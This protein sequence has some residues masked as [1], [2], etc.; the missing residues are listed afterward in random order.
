MK[1]LTT[2]TNAAK[3][4][5]KCDTVEFKIGL[6]DDDFGHYIGDLIDDD[7]INPGYLALVTVTDIKMF[8][9]TM[10]QLVNMIIEDY[11]I[12]AYVKSVKD[13][14]SCECCDCSVE[15]FWA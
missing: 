7:E 3:S 12:P 13:C 11:A 15:E 14:N 9:G 2:K 5:N 4:A 10:E 8:P 6:V 1:I